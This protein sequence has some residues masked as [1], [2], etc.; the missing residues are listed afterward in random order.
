MSDNANASEHVFYEN[1][2]YFDPFTYF[3]QDL[4]KWLNLI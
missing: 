3:V 2:E 4:G 1:W